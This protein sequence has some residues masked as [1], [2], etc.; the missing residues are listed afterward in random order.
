MHH[1]NGWNG[2]YGSYIK[3][4]L[5][6]ICGDNEKKIS[7]EFR[8]VGVTKS[9]SGNDDFGVK[10]PIKDLRYVTWIVTKSYSVSDGSTEGDLLKLANK[11]SDMSSQGQEAN[12]VSGM[13]VPTILGNYYLGEF[14]NGE[15]SLLAFHEEVK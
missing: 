1:A 9:T 8:L 5:G 10:P 4:N 15:M 6:P 2:F 7:V 14:T 3:K 13:Y 12:Y 11:E